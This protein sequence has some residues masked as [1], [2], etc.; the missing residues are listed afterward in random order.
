MSE[1]NPGDYYASKEEEAH[2]LSALQYGLNGIR[3]Y[4]AGFSKEFLS[5]VND[6]LKRLEVRLERARYVGD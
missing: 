4:S 2:R 5:A 1:H 3:W 6:E